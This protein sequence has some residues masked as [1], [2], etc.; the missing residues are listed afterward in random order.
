MPTRPQYSI[1]KTGSLSLP[2]ELLQQ[3]A[4]YLPAASAFSNKHICHA[5]RQELSGRVE[6][7]K[8]T[9]KKKAHSYVSSE[10]HGSVDNC[11]ELHHRVSDISKPL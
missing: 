8:S 10:T 11:D 1:S 9:K 6:K 5:T 2:V 3:I 4:R 7:G